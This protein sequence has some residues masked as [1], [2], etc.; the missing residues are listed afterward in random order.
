MFWWNNLLSK[1]NSVPFLNQKIRQIDQLNMDK[2]FVS[3]K[4]FNYKQQ[5]AFWKNITIEHNKGFVAKTK[6]WN[7]YGY[8][9]YESKKS[10]IQALSQHF[11]IQLG[12]SVSINVFQIQAS[13]SKFQLY[14]VKWIHWRMIVYTKSIISFSRIWP[15]R[16]WTLHIKLFSKIMLIIAANKILVKL[17]C[18][19]YKAYVLAKGF[20]RFKKKYITSIY[21]FW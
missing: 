18:L 1:L 17:R 7:N 5:S 16:L 6:N 21:S 8:L 19:N 10:I 20:S 3:F 2:L 15:K 14:K 12:L 11:N 13:L 9:L 4:S